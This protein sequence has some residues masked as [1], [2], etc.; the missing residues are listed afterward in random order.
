MTS[1][2]HYDTMR[3]GR[4][5]E[6]VIVKRMMSRDKL[7]RKA[8]RIL[9]LEKRSVWPMNPVTRVRESG[10]LYSRNKAKNVHIVE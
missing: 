10:K 1:G 3:A 5:E 9:D 4:T 2:C 6:V 8:R 7:S